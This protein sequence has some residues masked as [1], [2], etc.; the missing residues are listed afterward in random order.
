M[1]EDGQTE[2][3]PAEQGEIVGKPTML[4][5]FD[6][7]LNVE[8]VLDCLRRVEY[9]LEDVSVLFRIEGSDQVVDLTTGHVAAGQSLTD[10][11]LNAQKSQR[12]QT[13]VLLHP[14]GEQAPSVRKAL[15]E[16]GHPDFHPEIEYAGETRAHGR[17]GG[18]DRHDEH[19]S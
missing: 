4:A 19:V 9:P 2:G 15:L 18:V 17:P 16:I 10:E 7:M 14:T 1:V 8:Q 6:R 3:K 13:L 12:G 5:K 11:E